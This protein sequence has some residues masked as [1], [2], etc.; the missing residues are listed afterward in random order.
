MEESIVEVKLT[1]DIPGAKL[2]EPM[3]KSVSLLL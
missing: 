3:E 2:E 1:E